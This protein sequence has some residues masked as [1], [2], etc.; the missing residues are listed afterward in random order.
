MDCILPKNPT[1]SDTEVSTGDKNY[2]KQV[3]VRHY[4][5]CISIVKKKK[6]V[7]LKL[8]SLPPVL[9]QDEVL[10]IIL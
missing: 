7:S 9:K 2:L 8:S 5:I 1:C 6:K 3:I 10:Q 4:M